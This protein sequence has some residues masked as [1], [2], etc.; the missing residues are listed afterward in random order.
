MGELPAVTR[1]RRASR[2]I[3]QATHRRDRAI[4]DMRA[5]GASLREIA[6]VTGLTHSGVRKILARDED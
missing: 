2:Q 3:A 5:E 4:R 6:R 1:A